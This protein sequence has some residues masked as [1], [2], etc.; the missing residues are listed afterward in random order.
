MN[1]V[2]CKR[3]VIHEIIGKG[4]F[5]HVYKG[6]NIKSGEIVAIKLEDERT[7]TKLLKHEASLMKYLYDHDCRNTPVVYWYGLYENDACIV[8]PFYE[9]S[10]FD[11][12]ISYG[13]ENLAI[14]KI[15]QIMVICI[16]ILESIHKN[17]V[18]HRDIKPQNFMYK[19]KE[20]YLIDFG[21]STFYVGDG[22]EH[23][24][25]Q[26][27]NEHITGTP[28]YISYFIHEGLSASR[29][30][31]LISLGYMYIWLT[32]RELPW[33]DSNM[34]LKEDSQYDES[35]ILHWK[36]QERKR[37]KSLDN[38]ISLCDKTND[39]IEKSKEVLREPGVPPRI[40]QPICDYL[41]YSYGLDYK[42]TP[43]YSALC[44]LFAPN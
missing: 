25:I 23:I 1:I 43:N 18:I 42:T 38:L 40:N 14:E 8:M 3:Y 5:G 15:N 24:A 36:N 41:N 16:D 30:D 7:S 37:L 13:E 20:L 29:K 2:L 44:D 35:H 19:N 4:K 10:L 17:F 34:L 27:N 22:K 33:D 32:Y 21:L 39:V 28:K 26:D 31:D 12:I 6:K 9:C 11:K